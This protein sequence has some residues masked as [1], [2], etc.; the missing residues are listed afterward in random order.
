MVA[1]SHKNKHPLLS[2]RWREGRT[3]NRREEPHG[4]WCENL[5][6]K[7]ESIHDAWG[8][9]ITQMNQRLGEVTQVGL[10]VWA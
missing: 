3:L 6:G 1:C 4:T 9:P 10:G 8:P 2:A 5:V 7:G